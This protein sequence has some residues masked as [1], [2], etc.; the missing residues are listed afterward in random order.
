MG[1]TRI[2]R[3][4]RLTVV[5]AAGALILAACGDDST[6]P[7]GTQPGDTIALPDGTTP[8]T[9]VPA[10]DAFEH[11]TA[12]DEF[13]VEITYEGGFVPVDYQFA[14]IPTLL[15]AG[16]GQQYVPGPQI[17]IYPG[18]LLP[19]VQV[20]DIGEEGIQTLLALAAEHGLLT[21]REYESPTNIADA[22]DTVVTIRA[23]GG[24]Y[25]HRAYALGLDPGL[26]GNGGEIGDRAELAAFIEAATAVAPDIPQEPFG[27]GTYLVRATPIGDLGG[28]DLEPTLV[29][30][31]ATAPVRLADAGECSAVAA[32]DGDPLFATA[33]QLTFFTEAGVTYRLS[34]KPQLPGD[35]C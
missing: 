3:P 34:V 35:T 2:I 30:W 16:D 5:L 1:M 26:D 15:V 10:P 7:V 23:N 12:S 27:P 14:Q 9:T 4:R 25:T 8:P 6:A 33:N 11:P 28:F 18:P 13:V 29:A 20:A 22:P 19:N 21:V 32:T 31:P 24:T 17:A